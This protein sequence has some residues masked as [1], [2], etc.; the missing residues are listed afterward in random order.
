M[1]KDMTKDGR[2][3]GAQ[4]IDICLSQ[5]ADE[6]AVSVL[7]HAFNGV[8]PPLIGSYIPSERYIDYQAKIFDLTASMLVSGTVADKSTRHLLLN[9]LIKASCQQN[10]IELLKKLFDDEPFEWNGKAL[11]KEH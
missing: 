10:H 5:L 2:I 3:S 7:T 9:A 6:R 8:I 1:L 11:S 4:V